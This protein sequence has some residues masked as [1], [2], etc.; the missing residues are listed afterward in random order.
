MANDDR[1]MHGGVNGPSRGEQGSALIIAV[2]ITVILALLGISY[3]M[4]A[5]TENTIAENERNSAM[6]L[7]VAEAGA[8]LAVN[9]FNDPSSTG[10]LVPTAAQVDRTLRL[11]DHDSNPATA[12]VQAISANAA[13]PLYKDPAL[14]TV[15]IFDRPYRSAMRET[16]VGIET[17][18][19]PNP[20]FAT[21]GPDLVVGAAHLGT[22]NNAL[23]PNFPTNNL[24]A[25][26]VRIEFYAPP[27]VSIGG[28]ATRMGIATV[29][30]T[31]GVFMYPG[32]A[33]ERQ[34]ATRVVK[35]VV[36][37]IPIP[38]PGGPL[39]SCAGL[40]YQGNFQIHWGSGSS[41]GNALLGLTSGNVDNKAPT[42]WPYALD[43]HTSFYNNGA[44]NNLGSWA[45][46][47]DN[48][49]LEDPW[50]KFVAGGALTE[51]AGF[52]APWTPVDRQPWHFAAAPWPGNENTDHSNLFQNTVLT[53]P[54]F[55][56]ALWK[57]IAQSGNRNHFYFKYDTG[58]NFKLDGTG[59]AMSFETATGGR[60]GIMFFDTTDSLQPN[61]LLYSDPGS[62]LTPAI[63]ISNN[64][65]GTQGFIYLNAK[66][67]ETHGTGTSGITRTIIPPG[68]PGDAT[69]F[70]NLD[71]PGSFTGNL[72]VRDG[73]VIAESFQD[74][75]TGDWWCT[76]HTQC[77]T[78]GRI[79]SA[80][81]RQDNYG[82]PFQD[83]VCVDGVFYTSGTVEMSGNAKF[84]GSVITEQGV[85]DSSGTPEFY[86]D[87]SLIK[88]NWPRKG[89]NLP[90]VVVS[91]WQTDL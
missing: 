25:R 71:Y 14:T 70:V 87:E 62:N 55:D 22:I 78:G 4:M 15:S 8:R 39:Q 88:G 84:F 26:V 76:D 28:S 3:L 47:H 1:T 81:P 49:I 33:D 69:G 54:K 48:D 85:I 75:I 65:W 13:Q 34:I 37:E 63:D 91:A 51:V 11:L 53:C 6:A 12:R 74:P 89:M 43:D 61:G 58:G 68:E 44:G 82:L 56:Y 35:A 19:D 45:T 46:Q 30:V 20:A 29:K 31:G 83:K 41:Q 50:F 77:D 2:L 42:G 18:T 27:V 16:F 57:G 66:I 90:R 21:L 79:P 64:A 10:Y 5:Q 36:N 38:G 7:Y 67:F 80:T 9:W 24:R 17:G 86:F 59:T 52:G 73:T 32:T 40:S 23:F 60:S 72:R